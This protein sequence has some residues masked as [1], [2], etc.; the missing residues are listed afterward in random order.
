MTG[1]LLG[2]TY[3]LVYLAFQGIF[4][5]LGR[6]EWEG[7]QAGSR[8][9]HQAL[10]GLREARLARRESFFAAQVLQEAQRY[11]G[12]RLRGHLMG[13]TPPLAVRTLVFAGRLVVVLYILAQNRDPGY[14]VPVISLYALAGYRLLP[15]FA[16]AYLSVAKM[17]RALPTLQAVCLELEEEQPSWPAPAPRLRMLESLALEDVVFGYES[18]SVIEVSVAVA[19]DT[20]VAFVGKTGAGKSTLLALLTGLLSPTRGRLLVDGKE[21]DLRSYQRNL[22][23]V[24]QDIFLLNDTLARNVAF[25]IPDHDI[26]PERLREVGRLARL[27]DFVATLPE[28]W[29]TLVG[30]RGVRLSGGQRQRVGIARALYTDPD[31]LLF[32]EATAALDGQTEQAVMEA[33]EQLSGQK[34]IVLIAHRIRTVKACEVI[35]LLEHGHIVA[36]GSY[37][38]LWDTSPAFRDLAESTS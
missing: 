13:V 5:R 2:G 7:L 27:D 38:H 25:G 21:P 10:Q 37:Q 12:A 11:A 16:Q 14:A 8:L 23:L 15:A 28:G 22:G 24:P 26:D 1:L 9:K 30:E 3:S 6:S 29:K 33:L 36:S 4:R 32:D 31:I 34:T 20:K 35:H 17:R 19:K 18:D